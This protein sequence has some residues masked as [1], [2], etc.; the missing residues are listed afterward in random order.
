MP[1]TE[2]FTTQAGATSLPYTIKRVIHM[3]SET[4]QQ[5]PEVSPQ[6]E[7]TVWYN[8]ETQRSASLNMLD[9]FST[10]VFTDKVRDAVGKQLLDQLRMQE[11]VVRS[12]LK[13]D[14]NLVVIGDFK[15]GKS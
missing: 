13:S 5:A 14:F 15:R 9:N 8:P 6:S 11:S 10:W 1:A 3:A 7:R 4:P 2:A 12:R